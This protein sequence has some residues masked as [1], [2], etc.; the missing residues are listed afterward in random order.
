MA[1][2][3]ALH[4]SAYCGFASF[5][6]AMFVNYPELATH[7]LPV[8]VF[9]GLTRLG[10][11]AVVIF[12]V[13]SGFL[14]GGRAFER[15]RKGEFNTKSYVIDR[16]TRIFVPLIPAVLFSVIVLKYTNGDI[17]WSQVLGNLF[18]LQGVT[19]SALPDNVP[20]WTLSYEMWFYVS[21]VGIA[22]LF[23]KKWE[24]ILIMAVIAVIFTRLS[25]YYFVCWLIGAMAQVKLPTRISYTRIVAA[26]ILC[27]YGIIGIQIDHGSGG[28]NMK[29]LADL[30]PSAG[31]SRIMLSIGSAVIIRNIILIRSVSWIEKA[32]TILAASSYTLYLVHY[33]A[34]CLFSSY[35]GYVGIR[36]VNAHTLAQYAMLLGCCVVTVLALYLL[37]ERNT[38]RVRRFLNNFV[39]PSSSRV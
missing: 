16:S 30:L 36:V 32:G 34:L 28:I 23:R 26:A 18:A 4:S 3:A 14:V 37:F 8:A 6:E 13:L 39:R 12:F 20:L 29:W 11:E 19:T 21:V 22:L 2:L 24:G 10:N 15:I 7:S 25:P 33:P 9:F 38:N 1:R 35:L 5:P 17:V 27:V 31:I